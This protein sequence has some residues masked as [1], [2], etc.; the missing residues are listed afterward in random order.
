VD[1]KEKIPTLLS[2]DSDKLKDKTK[3]LALKRKSSFK[4]L[5]TKEIKFGDGTFVF[6]GYL[7]I[8][9]PMYF[10]IILDKI[11]LDKDKKY[12]NELMSFQAKNYIEKTWGKTSK[13]VKQIIKDLELFGYGKFDIKFAGAKKILLSN[14]NNPY[15][16]DYFSLFGRSKE[17]IDFFVC[18]LL[19]EAF[20][21]SNKPV[22]VKETQCIARGDK[23]C[24]FEINLI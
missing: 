18:L 16:L 11:I 19:K 7:G 22:E 1:E 13:D 23:G 14:I 20:A 24:S 6:R 17:P 10:K 5:G 12:F 21:A 8:N 2:I 9:V 3:Q 4:I 15:P